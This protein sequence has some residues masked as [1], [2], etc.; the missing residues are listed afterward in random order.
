MS[1][2]PDSAAKR[3]A[4]KA[5][6]KSR[7]AVGPPPAEA[8][9]MRLQ[10]EL[11]VHQAELEAQN[12]NLRVTQA[13]LQDAL[14]R[15]TEIYDC[16]PVA[17]LSLRPDGEIRQLNLAAATLLGAERS[18]L[19]NRCLGQFLEASDRAALGRFLK[20]VF[21]GQRHSCEVTLSEGVVP[22]LI[23]RIEVVSGPSG[24]ECQAVMINIAERKKA[25]EA[26]RGS[27]AR[28]A[29]ALDAAE[30][31]TWEWELATGKNVWSKKLWRLYGLVPDSCEASYEVW[32][33]V[34]HPEDRERIERT[35]V[36]AVR[37]EAEVNLEWR[38]R[39]PDGSDRWLMSRG[40]PVRDEAG[41][42]IR[43]V[44]VVVDVSDRK[45]A[46]DE[47][48]RQAALISSLLDSI[49]DIVF[50]KN[51]EG[52]YLGCNPACVEIVGRPR[53][54]IIGKT[55]H[56]L[57]DKETA[58]S[59]R[60]QDRRMLA[61]RE[62]LHKEEWGTYPDGRK[63]LLET[64]K[65]PYWGPDGELIGVL[66]ISR[67]VTA[68]RQAM[69][70]LEESEQTAQ[71]TINAIP[72]HLAILNGSG[73]IIMVN[74]PWRE[75]ARAHGTEADLC[76][77]A[78]YLAL[79][80]TAAGGGCAEAA[81]FAGGFRAVIEGRRDQF[82]FEYA[83][84]SPD[85][86]R[87]FLARV[88]RFQRGKSTY[89][90]VVHDNIT[91][92]KQ[93]EVQ[94]QEGKARLDQ[95]A[96][97]SRTFAWEVDAAG[98]YTYVSHVAEIV[99][100]YH[101]EE[102]VGRR[103]FYDLHPETGREEFKEAGFAALAR[104]E[105]FVDL[106]NAVVTKDGRL[107][108]VSTNGIPLLNVDG[109]LRGYRGSGTDVTERR[110]AEDDV[111]RQ[112]AL[113]SSL[114]DAIPDIVFFKSIEGVY[115]ICNP[116][117]AEFVGRPRSEIIGKTDREVFG[118]ELG[119]SFREQDRQMLATRAPRH[120]EE[121]IAC[122]RGQKALF[123]RL[124]TP[125]WGPEGEII[126]VLGISR[127]I[128]AQRQAAE[129]LRQTNQFLEA[130]N[131][132]ASG[133]AEQATQA[134]RA[135]SE[136]LAAMSHEI[137]T[138]MNAVLGMTNLLLKT[139]LDPRQ[140]EFARTVASSGEA[141]LH[142][143][144]D[145]LDLSKIEAGGQFPID[146]QPLNLHKLA[147]GVVQMLQSRAEERGLA[148][149][150]DVAADIPAWVRGDAVRL[151]QVLI[152][153]AGNG[154]KFT[155]RGGVTI[156]LRRLESEDPRVRL[157]FEVQDTGIGISAE[158]GARLFQPF[159]QVD[160]SASR[161]RGGTGLGLVIS[162]RIVEL[163]DGCIGLD[164]V[165]GQGSMFWFEVALEAASAPAAEAEASVAIE[166][167]SSQGA[168]A[169]KELRILVAEDH[170]PNRRL[171]MYMLESLGCRAD[172][173][174][175][176]RDAVDAWERSTYDI[177]IMDCQ[178]PGMD[179][180][181][182]TREIRRREAARSRGGRTHIVAL[183][184]NAVKGDRERCLASGMDCYLS[185]PYTAQQLGA[186]LKQ[187]HAPPAPP[188]AFDP[189]RPAQLCAELGDEG[190]RGIIEDYLGEL[191]GQVAEIGALAKAGRRSKA[192][193]LAHSLRGISL[194][195]GLVEFGA[196][197]WEI[198]EMAE[199][200]DDAGLGRLLE[201]LPGEA[202]QAH[203]ELR[204]WMGSVERGERGERGDLRVRNVNAEA[205]RGGAATIKTESWGGKPA[206]PQ[207]A[208]PFGIAAEDSALS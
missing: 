28:R 21:E 104:R 114:L 7:G 168:V 54:E 145:I 93:I 42:M 55:D 125:H 39:K 14:K 146:A 204:G 137:R 32:R 200:G 44:G 12:E 34:M 17:Y 75:F 102:I 29:L 61:K 149:A 47:V 63:A 176:G 111:R 158:D 41:R 98:L 88:T 91:G 119:D 184:A 77:G 178:M 151:R 67:D 24:Q 25:D 160:S 124:K 136:F 132:R 15:Y 13:K 56:E 57:F 18:C 205:Q 162:K 190:V 112:A 71:G 58:D 175:N 60:E 117:F 166:T 208:A 170:E 95:L 165:P 167:D 31:G 164:S 129:E 85:E 87:W 53:N 35:V 19:V 11:E 154:L 155:E 148:L 140:T 153:L 8:D 48:W 37:M 183:T 173:A 179:G 107:R 89:V 4:V 188:V 193:R 113:I 116:A 27:E 9:L 64:L 144:N 128:T 159:I 177:I 97:Q 80:D 72:G 147:G 1:S 192:G 110:H 52:V 51:T 195:F 171:A 172:F 118:K 197:L 105:P 23:V 103:H 20:G 108:W 76:E 139:P 185:K 36:E 163:M 141:L 3:P 202:E 2:T 135:K 120:H 126:G 79:C 30:A 156:R 201:L 83:C 174:V 82:D 109:T 138:P 73:I 40:R 150:A 206:P 69:A 101:A 26:L 189:Q 90:A 196:H 161:R 33:Q 199:G 182:A 203:A 169:A 133:L 157:R 127:D 207:M 99:L 92:R 38:V 49:P 142:I 130:A 186:V 78:N 131:A 121:W 46:E 152:N 43:Y 59:F 62:P 100:G 94:V 198:E 66:G 180:F 68:Q 106:L 70:A 10:R 96:E 50:F 74:R 191:P 81:A 5:R 6:K 65:T 123:D 86:K 134:S 115:L 194:S 84:H 122:P 22:P 16:G 143:I 45:R 187:P 181:E